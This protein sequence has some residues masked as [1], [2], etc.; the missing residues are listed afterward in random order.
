MNVGAKTA[1]KELFSAAWFVIAVSLN[2]PGFPLYYLWSF[3]DIFQ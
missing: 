3:I 1:I 2:N